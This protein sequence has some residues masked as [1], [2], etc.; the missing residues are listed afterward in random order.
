[1]VTVGNREKC[2]DPFF[3]SVWILLPQEIVK[4]DPHGV[5]PQSL[6][7][8]EF[9]VDLRRVEAVCLPH[10]QLVDRVFRNVVRPDKPALLV[11]PG[12]C[13]LF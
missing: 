10:F 9:L 8:A 4:K 7:P 13:F 12:I 3:E 6:R 5:P 11:V 2:V 1:M